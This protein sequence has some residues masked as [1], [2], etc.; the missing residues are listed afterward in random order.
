[1]KNRRKKFTLRVCLPVVALLA[2]WPARAARPVENLAADPGYKQALRALDEGI[3]QVS[4]QKLNEC[5][6]A[7]LSAEDRSL[8]TLQLARALL[9]AGQPAD[10]LKALKGMTAARE[11]EAN[12]LKARALSALDRWEEACPIYRQL[13]SLPGAPLAYKIGEAECLHASNKTAEAIRVLES[14]ANDKNAG[15][16]V[17]LRLADFYLEQNQI[18]KCEAIFNTVQPA[19]PAESKWKHYIEGRLFLEKRHDQQ[20]FDA[21]QEVLETP[22]GLS[23]NL[24]V[25]ATLGMTEARLALSGPEAADNVIEEFIGRHP[26]IAGIGLLFQRLDRIYEMEKAPSDSELQKW[27]QEKQSPSAPLATFY[28]AKAY[29]RGQKFDKALKTFS[30]FMSAWPD[31]PLL[32]EA[33]LLEGSI[34]LDQ[35][36]I[37][38]AIHAFEAAMVRARDGELLAQAEMAAATAYFKQREFAQAQRL[39]R[40]AAQHSDRLWQRAVFNSALSW[41]N[42]ANYDK[43]LADY[44]ELSARYPDSELRSDLA[45]QEG[46]HQARAGDPQ[47]A[48]TLQRFVRD[49]PNHPHVAE[50]RLALAEIEFLSPDRNLSAASRYLKAVNETPPSGATP[51]RAEYLAIFLEDTG[52]SQE[53]DKMIQLCQQFI[54]KHPG[55]PLLADVRMKL[56]QVYF[57]REDFLNAQ[58]QFELLAHELPN[59]PYAESAL[60]LAGQ[61][62]LKTMNTDSALDLFQ[63]VVNRNGPLKLYARQQQAILKSRLGSEQ[64]AITLYD[65]ILD[66]KP[67]A[68]LKFAALCGKGYDYF[69]L[70]V[71][72]VKYFEQAVATFNELAGQTD[73]SAYWRNQALY[74]KGKCFEK[75]GEFFE[76]QNKRD[77]A[78]AKQSEALAAFYDVIQPPENRGGEPE[79]FWFYKAGFDAGQILESQK[80][81]K[82][83]IAVYQK[84]AALDGPRS[85]EA[86]DRVTHLRLEHFISEE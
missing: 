38:L 64:Q 75:Q 15:I 12:F 47:A 32:A 11:I 4:I 55:S 60:F 20:A 44:R 22:D 83:A 79:Y 36:K 61:S 3:P 6:A 31:S 56:G 2:A 37:P 21:F 70:G 86:R 73:V 65:N 27:A 45:L 7:K 51:E 17:S 25:G 19:T 72:D 52:G 42:Q 49:F 5:L 76:N 80:Q 53:E 66:A 33:C 18:E 62:A 23:E 63:E 67:D 24:M 39:F 46:L 10:A 74:W 41:L 81:W 14:V 9:A 77:E 48:A 1:M 54:K 71:K 13:A 69:L 35:Q 85:E 8:A 57:R 68:D 29:A 82:A 34:L 16:L 78:A 30:D 26:D 50:A 58:T 28:L 40:S 59:S 43:F 84:M